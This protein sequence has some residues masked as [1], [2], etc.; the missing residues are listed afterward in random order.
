M[1]KSDTSNFEFSVDLCENHNNLR[2]HTIETLNRI[3]TSNRLLRDLTYDVTNDEIQSQIAIVKGESIIIYIKRDPY[4]KFKI[5]VPAIGTTVLKLKDTIKRYH[6]ALQ[7]REKN[8]QHKYSG[9]AAAKTNEISTSS[10]A[11]AATTTTTHSEPITKIS[12]KYVWR[13]YFLE[14]NGIVLSDDEQ[15]LLHYDI[16]NKATLGFVK[17]SKQRKMQKKKR[18][19]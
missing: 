18:D 7:R 4:Q 19:K 9:N 13:T 6:L 8:R 14:Y 2:N 12:W 5:I 3:F 16:K 15:L 11:E 1:I 17:K 10:Q